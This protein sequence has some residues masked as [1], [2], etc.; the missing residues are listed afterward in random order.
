MGSQ[1]QS[2][3]LRCGFS[4]AADV[5]DWAVGKS[6]I[7]LKQR[8]L[9]LEEMARRAHSSGSR[10]VAPP[11]AGP[12]HDVSQSEAESEAESE[13]DGSVPATPVS[14]QKGKWR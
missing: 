3:N 12:Y 7:D 8:N 5:L 10:T 11:H 1:H 2:R 6:I 14:K 9:L 13:M 4:Y